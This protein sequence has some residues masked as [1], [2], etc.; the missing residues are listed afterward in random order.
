MFV[1]TP[2]RTFLII[3]AFTL[4]VRD[5]AELP[6]EVAGLPDAPSPDAVVGGV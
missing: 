3:V 6:L 5:I 1:V 2:V 4:V